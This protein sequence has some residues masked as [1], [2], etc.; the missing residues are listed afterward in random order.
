MMEGG[1]VVPSIKARIAAL[2]ELLRQ[3]EPDI[4]NI[5]YDSLDPLSKAM[6]DLVHE[7]EALDTVEKKAAYCAEHDMT[8]VELEGF[9]RAVT[10]D[11]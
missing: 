3:G 7:L 8:T 2:Q 11:Y 4:R 9:I 1:E 10:V 5:P 6:M